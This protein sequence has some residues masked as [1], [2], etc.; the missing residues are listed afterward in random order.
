MY[1]KS[2]LNLVIMNPLSVRVSEKNHEFLQEMT[3]SGKSKTEIVNDALDFLRKKKLQD[4]LT[5]MA[6]NN[7]N[8]DAL[9]AEEGMEDYLKL[10]NDA[11]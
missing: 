6:T 2:V 11:A 5:S 8:D 4:E 3:T 7:G 10:L 9:L 1:Y